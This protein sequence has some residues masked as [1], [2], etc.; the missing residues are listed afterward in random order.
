MLNVW[1]ELIKKVYLRELA[2]FLIFSFFIESIL[3]TILN[4]LILGPALKTFEHLLCLQWFNLNHLKHL[5]FYSNTVNEQLIAQ[6][7]PFESSYCFSSSSIVPL[8]G[9]RNNEKNQ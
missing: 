4:T 7:T 3:A 8:I 2:V 1:L 5:H 6:P 9:S